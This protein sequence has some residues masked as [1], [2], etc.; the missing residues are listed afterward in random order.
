MHIDATSITQFL[1]KQLKLVHARPVQ[2]QRF[3]KLLNLVSTSKS[4]SKVHNFKKQ[5]CYTTILKCLY[6]I[7]RNIPYQ[8]WQSCGGWDSNSHLKKYNIT[9]QLF[10][11]CQLLN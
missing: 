3:L 6:K 4:D 2:D 11:A 7:A 1:E 9:E 8:G 10:S 5:E